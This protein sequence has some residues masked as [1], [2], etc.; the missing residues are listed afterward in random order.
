MRRRTSGEAA[1]YDVILD[2][3]GNHPWSDIKRAITPEGTFVLIGNDHYGGSGH[4]LVRQPGSVRQA[5][6][7]LT[8]REPA[9]VFRGVKDPGDRLVVMK[10][11]I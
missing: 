10:E 2:V 1:S 6:R 5:D 9:T 3:A 7:D 11:L 4:R 8:I